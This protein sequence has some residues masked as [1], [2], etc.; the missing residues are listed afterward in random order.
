MLAQATTKPKDDQAY[1]GWS[2]IQ[3][4]TD[5]ITF[6]QWLNTPEDIAWLDDEEKSSRFQRNGFH[7]MEPFD[8]EAIGE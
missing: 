6:D 3:N 7:D 4:A 5:M 1:A 2:E 8:Y